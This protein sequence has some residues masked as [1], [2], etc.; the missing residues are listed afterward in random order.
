MEGAVTTVDY[1]LTITF[2]ELGHRVDLPDR[3]LTILLEKLPDAGPVIAHNSVSGT[4]T[5]MLGLVSSDPIEDVSRLSKELGA[6]MFHAGLEA[7]PAIVDVHLAA[8]SDEREPVGA[9]SALSL[10]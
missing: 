5:V 6:A 8:V 4:L 9:P 7:P 3:L 2:A 1:Q 10:V